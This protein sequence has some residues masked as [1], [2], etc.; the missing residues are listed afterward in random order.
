MITY[1][2]VKELME[3]MDEGESRYTLVI[4]TAKRARQ[5]TNGFTAFATAESEKPVSIAAQEIKDGYITC[6][7]DANK[8]VDVEDFGEDAMEIDADIL[9]DQVVEPTE[10]IENELEE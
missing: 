2:S 8:P 3:K 1:P 7:K 5:L 9:F 4:A 10:G 6:L